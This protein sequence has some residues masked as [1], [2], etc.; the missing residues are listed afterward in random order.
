MKPDSSEVVY[1]GKAFAVVAEEWGDRRR[2]IV[3]H[4]GSVAIVAVGADGSITLV[5]Q[6]REPARMELVEL[7]AGTL[8]EGEEPL[9]TAKRELEEECGLT[10]GEWR[11]LGRFW[12]SPGFLDEQ[13]T[14]FAAE[15]VERGGEQDLDEDEDVE[16][17]RWRFDEVEE[18]IGELE[19]AK[20]VAGLLLYLRARTAS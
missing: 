4:P 10:G 12:T 19:D 17:V 2:E 18:R 15:G 11:E 13:M 8:E 5:R 6:L 9:A 7:P 16:L 20:T 1:E 14:I 3:T